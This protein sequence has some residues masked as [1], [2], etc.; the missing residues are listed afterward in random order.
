MQLTSH[1]CRL[2]DQQGHHH[3]LEDDESNGSFVDLL[4]GH[5]L[6][7][8]F[9][10]FV[11]V[12]VAGGHAAQIEQ[13][14]PER[15]RQE[16]S[17][18]VHRDDDAEPDQ[19]DVEFFGHRRQQRH[20]D[21]GDLEEVNEEAQRK[22]QDV[23]EDEE[24]DLTPRQLVKQ[25]FHPD[26]SIG[27]VE[28]ERKH[29]GADQDEHHENGK[30]GAVLQGLLEHGERE[31]ATD[32]RHDQGTQC[33]HGTALGRGGN[34]QKDGAEHQEDQQQ[35][36]DQHEGDLLG[37]TGDQVEAEQL[38]GQGQRQGKQGTHHHRQDEGLVARGVTGT[39]EP[40]LHQVVVEQ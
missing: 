2:P 35:R 30:F 37:Q 15:R 34:A 1:Q 10:D 38:V 22:H 23:H 24:A 3:E 9:R 19:V 39:A 31:T 21:E 14:K 5:A 18:Q 28:S 33:A 32:Q 11:H 36:R 17:L 25:M 13:R 6:D 29:G 7:R 20:H 8:L 12:I 16:R 4:R 40:L 26:V 27:R